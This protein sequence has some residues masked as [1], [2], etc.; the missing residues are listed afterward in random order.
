MIKVNSNHIYM[1]RGD[2][3]SFNCQI[4]YSNSSKTEYEMQTGDTL[5]FTVRTKA[6]NTSGDDYLIQ[7]SSTTNQI[8]L[9]PE[10]TALLNYGDYV[11]DIQ[12]TLIDGSINT[13]IPINKITL[14]EEVT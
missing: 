9:L 3:V 10:D 5:V 13:I 14:C 11:Y 1:T 8:A 2:T 6:K 7:K 12:L 4:Q